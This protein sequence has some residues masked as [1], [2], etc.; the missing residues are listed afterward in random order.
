MKLNNLFSENEVDFIVRVK[1]TNKVYLLKGNNIKIK[2][3]FMI[4]GDNYIK[5]DQVISAVKY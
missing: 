2:G 3:E 4:I 5:K 1:N